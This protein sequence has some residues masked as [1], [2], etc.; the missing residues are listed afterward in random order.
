MTFST[1]ND[2]ITFRLSQIQ[3]FSFLGRSYSMYL[4]QDS[5]LRHHCWTTFLFTSILLGFR[6]L[7]SYLD[8]LICIK[9]KTQTK[10]NFLLYIAIPFS[11]PRTQTLSFQLD[12]FLCIQFK[13]QTQGILF[14]IHFHSILSFQDLT[15]SFLVRSPYVYPLQGSNLRHPSWYTFTTPLYC[16][17]DLEP[18][19]PSQIFFC[20]TSLGLKPQASQL[21]YITISCHLSKTQTLNFLFLFSYVYPLQGQNLGILASIHCYSSSI[22]L[23]LRP[24][25]S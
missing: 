20:V 1:L 14:G 18:Q 13:T 9:F 4:A 5:D 19:Q 23:K 6:P 21:V 8:P 22:F 16:F 25:A 11:L 2:N 3:T 7:A 15:L 24:L 17:Q 12:L 10:G